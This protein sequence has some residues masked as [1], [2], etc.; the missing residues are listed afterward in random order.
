MPQPVPTTKEWDDH[1][2]ADFGVP[3]VSAVGL[4]DRIG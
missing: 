3:D 4:V 1:A 2:Q